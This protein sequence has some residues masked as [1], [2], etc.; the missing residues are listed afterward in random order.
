[1]FKLIFFKMYL[2]KIFYVLN[3]PQTYCAEH[4]CIQVVLM[5]FRKR[6]YKKLLAKTDF[7]LQVNPII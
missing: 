6:G 1:M 2:F 3:A 4:T 5:S 7:L